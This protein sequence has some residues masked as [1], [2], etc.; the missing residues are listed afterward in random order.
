MK[1]VIE[2]E[3]DMVVIVDIDIHTYRPQNS[4]INIKMKLLL[5]HIVTEV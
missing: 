4:F 2:V 1:S 5:D 3:C